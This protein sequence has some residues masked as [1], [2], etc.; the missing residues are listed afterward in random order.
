M[1]NLTLSVLVIALAVAT[2]AQS[3]HNSYPRVGRID[4][5]NTY[6]NPI[7]GLRIT[8]PGKWRLMVPNK[9]AQYA[10]NAQ[11]PPDSSCRG[12]LC[13]KPE[14]DE[15]L[16][17]DSLPV[18]TLF[19]IGYRLQPEYLNRQRYPL[20]RFAEAM[21]QGSLAG[22]EWVPMGGM[23]QIQI[24]GRQAYRLLV[25][26][27]SRPGKKGF[28]FAFEANGYV[29]LLIGTDITASQSLL[30]AVER[31]TIDKR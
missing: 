6:I 15:A 27:P 20:S 11:P 5:L 8:V 24:A 3:K 31:M 4:G 25:H 2:A 30:P 1:K 26:D 9:Y 28:G 16:E 10:P 12:P 7:L 17:T 19:L 22:S 13:G 21:M 14:I 29:C 18:Q 23:S